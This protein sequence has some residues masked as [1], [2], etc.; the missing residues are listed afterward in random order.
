V[1]LILEEMLEL[2]DMLVVQAFVKLQL[3]FNNL[4]SSLDVKSCLLIIP[5]MAKQ[6]LLL[7]DLASIMYLRLPLKRS[8]FIAFS[9]TPLSQILPLQI[10]LL[11]Y[12]VPRL[13]ITL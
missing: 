7:Y 13:I 5:L 10:R 3:L 12:F 2:N 4:L 8:H 9:V 6:F 11:N 1:V